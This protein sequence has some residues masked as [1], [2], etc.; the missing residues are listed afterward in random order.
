MAIRFMTRRIEEVAFGL[1]A[2]E[3]QRCELPNNRNDSLLQQGVGGGPG[4]QVKLPQALRDAQK[5]PRLR[6]RLPN[7]GSRPRTMVVRLL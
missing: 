1:G 2:S 3:S 5:K 7:R 4:L 6:S